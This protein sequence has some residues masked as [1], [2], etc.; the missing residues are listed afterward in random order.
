MSER[1]TPWPMIAVIALGAAWTTAL[2]TH[3]GG[4]A[5]WPITAWLWLTAAAGAV[6]ALRRSPASRDKAREQ[7]TPATT[8]RHSA[9]TRVSRGPFRG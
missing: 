6:R 7:V 4:A 8:R 5:L 3:P 2:A 9:S 1:S